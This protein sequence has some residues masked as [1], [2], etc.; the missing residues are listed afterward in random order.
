METAVECKLPVKS[1][2]GRAPRCK[3]ETD[4]NYDVI[5]DGS[6][7]T[8]TTALLDENEEWARVSH[9]RHVT[10]QLKLNK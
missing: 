8:V 3:P 5:V 4:D 7:A 6:Q 2:G 1:P 9:G 10:T